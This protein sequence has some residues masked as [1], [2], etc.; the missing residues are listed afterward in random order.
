M[1][2]VLEV[3]RRLHRGESQVVI[4]LATGRDRKTIR[5]YLKLAA[6]LG[7]APGTREPDESLAVR[8]VE[9]LRPGPKDL[10]PG[11]AERLLLPHEGRIREWLAG[12]EN[13]RGLTLTKVRRLLQRQGIEV[14]Y[15]SLHRFVA[16]HCDF[17]S[18]RFTVRCADTRPG[19]LSEID[20]GRLGYVFDP[21]TARRR[22][23]WALIVVL[24]Y[25]RHMY[26]HITSTQRL[27]DVIEGL[28]AAWMFFGGVT[29]R[30]VLDNFKAAIVK[31]ARYEPVFQRTFS[32]YAEH[33]GFV[34][35]PAVAYH[36]EGKPHVER[37]VPYVRENFFRGEN[38]I[39]PDHVQREANRWCLEVAGT[40]THGTTHR[41]PL[42]VFEE[43]ERPALLP[44]IGERFDTP[45]W[46]ECSVHPD[47]H[48]NFGKALYSVPHEF[49]RKKVTVRGDRALVRIYFQGRLIKTHSPQKPGRR[50]TDYDDYPKP[51][52]AYAR[53]DPDYMI[54]EATKLG[55]NIGRFAE[56]LLSGDFPWAKLRQAQ[57]LMRLSQKYGRPRLEEA[58]GRALAF[59]LINVFRLEGIVLR[60]LRQPSSQTPGLVTPLP[61]RFLRPPGSF[62]HPTSTPKEI[63]TDGDQ[64]LPQSRPQTP[65]ALGHPGHHARPGGL[66]HEGQAD[67]GGL[68]GTDPPG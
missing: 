61:A 34:I 30:T 32:E 2:E 44:I 46:A 55:P 7:W 64:A 51:L 36:P 41:H 31:A 11:Q 59:D 56:K 5:S 35:D 18:G 3:L 23:L 52:G 39:N 14:P 13:E 57:K 50:S 25:S 16:K 28:E 10:E 1:W 45:R 42:A 67:S 58:C 21:E 17:G 33:R 68:P 24:V 26:V 8:I 12:Q 20:F 43:E 65:E 22:L 60:A 48:V 47:H 37:Q 49:L 4:G 19:E 63:A 40:R 38:W 53:R 54:Q 9:K 66:R 62:T 15:S 29:A 6:E 27:E